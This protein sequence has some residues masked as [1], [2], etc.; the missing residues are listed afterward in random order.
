MEETEMGMPWK[1]RLKHSLKTGNKEFWEE[2]GLRLPLFLKLRKS[3][4]A[5]RGGKPS[6]WEIKGALKVIAKIG[7]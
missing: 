4:G 6:F 1:Q 2:A 5:Y 3:A 7:I